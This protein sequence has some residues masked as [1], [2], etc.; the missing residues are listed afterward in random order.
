[1]L[2]IRGRRAYDKLP[3]LSAVTRLLVLHA[4]LIA[5]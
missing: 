1:V 5:F 2:V 4:P 3:H